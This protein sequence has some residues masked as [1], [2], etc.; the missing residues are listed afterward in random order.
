MASK[1]GGTGIGIV[2]IAAAGA[3]GIGANVGAEIVGTGIR[4]GIGGLSN[5]GIV[6]E[7]P[8]IGWMG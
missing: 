8:G 6:G 4:H 3:L 5:P 7:A 2:G 1:S